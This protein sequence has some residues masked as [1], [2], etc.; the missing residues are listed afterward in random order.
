MST[1]QGSIPDLAA[2]LVARRQSVNDKIDL[3]RNRGA[4]WTAL[5]LMR[6]ALDEQAAAGLR[7]SL[8]SMLQFEQ[9]I[10]QTMERSSVPVRPPSPAV[11]TDAP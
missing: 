2:L 7:G 11:T 4:D 5:H 1:V 3:L 6:H 9:L 8:N 10:D